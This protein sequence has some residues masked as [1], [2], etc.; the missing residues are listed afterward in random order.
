MIS[1][2]MKYLQQA[3]RLT[4]GITRATAKWLTRVGGYAR[5]VARN[6]LKVA[7]PKRS[8][9]ELTDWELDRWVM[10]NQYRERHG[11]SIPAAFPD[12]VS[13]PGQ[14]P[15]L[16]Q[17]NSPLKRVLNFQINAAAGDVVIGPERARSATAHILESGGGRLMARPFMKPA[18]A[19][20]I[21]HM[22]AWWHNAIT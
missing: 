12:R 10:L 15:L 7:K 5:K 22:A 21:P 20:T 13:K 8:D 14:P 11:L 16:H 19:K 17:R 2:Q 1:W 6:S 4:R 3:D 9:D 18:E